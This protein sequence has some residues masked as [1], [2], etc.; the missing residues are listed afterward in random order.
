MKKVYFSPEID[1]IDIEL[2]SILAA[3]AEQ[4]QVVLKAMMMAQVKSL[5]RNI[6]AFGMNG[7]SSNL[8]FFYI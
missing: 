1:V 6:I 5:Q 7:R 8:P 3:S 4:V 2:E